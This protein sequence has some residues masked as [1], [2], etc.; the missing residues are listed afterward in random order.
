M[1]FVLNEVEETSCG[2]VVALYG[3]RSVRLVVVGV[4]LAPVVGRIEDPGPLGGRRV[5]EWNLLRAEA[6]SEAPILSKAGVSR[7]LRRSRGCP[8]S[9]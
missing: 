4:L 7:T 5:R 3:K 8:P 2:A 6:V 1:L 9:R